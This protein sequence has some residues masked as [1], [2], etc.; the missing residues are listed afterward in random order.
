MLTRSAKMVRIGA[1]TIPANTR[2]KTKNRI[3]LKPPVTKAS[4]SLFTVMV[5]ISAAKAA[6]DLPANRIAVIK[7]PSSRKIPKDTK[8]P[9]NVIAP[10][11]SIP[12]AD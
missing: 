7:G 5:P 12:I 2:G 9:T 3:G 6:E 4:T 1:T 8:G 11:F 10:N